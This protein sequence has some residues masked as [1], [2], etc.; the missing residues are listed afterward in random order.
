MAIIS[1]TSPFVL[2]GTAVALLGGMIALGGMASATAVPRVTVWRATVTTTHSVP[3]MVI[4]GRVMAIHGTTITVRT[5]AQRPPCGAGQICPMYVI[6]GTTFVV[7]SSTATHEAAN[8]RSIHDRLAVGAQVVVVGTTT[9]SS[10]KGVH[11]LRASVVERIVTTT[12]A[13]P[14]SKG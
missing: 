6:A 9:G 11:R 3:P 2:A 4:Q 1:R 8:G 14:M 12:G 10:V 7:D 13:P 5:P